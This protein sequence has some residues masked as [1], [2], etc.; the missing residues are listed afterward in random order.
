M[1][2]D[3][4]LNVYITS[5][6]PPLDL[7]FIIRLIKI[8]YIRTYIDLCNNN[9][10]AFLLAQ[11]ELFGEHLCCTQFYFEHPYLHCQSLIS[12]YVRTIKPSLLLHYTVTTG[13]A[14][15]CSTECRLIIYK[16]RHIYKPHYLHFGAAPECC[17]KPW[18]H[19]LTLQ[20]Y[21]DA[22]LNNHWLRENHTF[23]NDDSTDKSLKT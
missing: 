4:L 23:G 17:W 5:P 20:Q 12:L 18:Q 2:F 21:K 1:F 22:T 19:F 8:S 9:F 7:D 13:F 10:T 14:I 3:T 15:L 16:L 6:T 11:Q